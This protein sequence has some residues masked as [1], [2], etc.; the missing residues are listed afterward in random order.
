MNTSLTSVP[1]LTIVAQA[2][3]EFL[4]NVIKD[5]NDPKFTPKEQGDLQ[6]LGVQV[7]NVLSE[8]ERLYSE[9]KKENPKMIPFSELLKH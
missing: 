9:H 7:E 4:A 1:S 6:E 3:D 5:S 8:V 2:L